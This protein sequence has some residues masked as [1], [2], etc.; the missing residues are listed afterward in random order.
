RPERAALIARNAVALGVPELRIVTA[1]APAALAGLPRPDAIFL[2]GGIAAPGI[3]EALWAAL[4][5]GGR[6][7]A[8]AVTLEGEARLFAF[9][10]EHGGA[11]TRLAVSRAEPLGPYHA[12]RPLLPVTQLAA[13]KLG[14]GALASP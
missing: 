4:A 10:R 3:L 11:L 12:W 14:G 8:N 2:G 6:L 13:V 7:V 9:R 1:A 5:A